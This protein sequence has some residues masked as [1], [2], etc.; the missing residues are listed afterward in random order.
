MNSINN[1]L[2]NLWNKMGIHVEATKQTNK[3]TGDQ[4]TTVVSIDPEEHGRFTPVH[5]MM[6]SVV[7][8]LSS[9]LLV[10]K[11]KHVL[12]D[13]TSDLTKHVITLRNILQQVG[14]LGRRQ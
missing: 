12:T 11:I 13:S 4:D 14:G 10:Q 3:Q 9:F 6:L 5:L 7:S 8:F 2:Y 1:L